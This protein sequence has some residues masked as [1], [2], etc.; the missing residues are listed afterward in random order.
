[1]SVDPLTA[2][3]ECVASR[4]PYRIEGGFVL[5]GANPVRHRIPAKART[6]FRSK[7]GQ[8]AHYSLGDLVFFLQS[9]ALPYGAY[10][11]G[12]KANGVMPVQAVDKKNLTGAGET[13]L[14]CCV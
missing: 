7:S 4:A 9:V 12:A 3:R 8:G 13:E 2:L 1:M 5:L 14:V 10:I 11:V 6:I